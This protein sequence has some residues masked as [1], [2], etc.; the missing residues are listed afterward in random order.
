MK[1]K[2][3]KIVIFLNPKIYS[4]EAIYGAAYVFLDK[5]YVF[6]E[7]APREKIKITLKG[8]KELTGKNLEVLRGEFLNELLN[9]SL[10]EQ[11]SKNNKK[12]REYIIA[13]ALS[14][15]VAGVSDDPLDQMKTRI[16]FGLEKDFQEEEDPDEIPWTGEKLKKKSANQKEMLWAKDPLGIAIPWEKKHLTKKQLNKK[17]SNK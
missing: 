4:L 5:S 15:A 8:K 2:E 17:K 7:E 11:I 1:K 6:L 14:S 9:F 16:K 3:N 13:K 10:R 12:I